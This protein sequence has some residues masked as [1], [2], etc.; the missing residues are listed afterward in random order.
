VFEY[1]HI[2]WSRQLFNAKTFLILKLL[3]VKI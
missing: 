1:M 3:N 2:Y